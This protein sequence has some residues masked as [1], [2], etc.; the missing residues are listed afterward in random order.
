MATME[1]RH[2]LTDKQRTYQPCIEACIECL[3]ACEVCSD[4][5]L[6]AEMDMSA[7]IRTDR[8]CADAC[9]AALRTMARGGP[10]VAELCTACAEECRRM[11]M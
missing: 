5:C 6:D 3:I 7:C 10:M 4:A 1:I 11:T 2:Y 8:V 9:T